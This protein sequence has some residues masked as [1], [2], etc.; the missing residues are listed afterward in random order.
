MK[1]INLFVFTFYTKFNVFYMSI[2]FGQVNVCIRTHIKWQGKIGKAKDPP[3][4][5]RLIQ[6]PWVP[7]YITKDDLVFYLSL[8]R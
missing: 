2:I 1:C 3:N 4:E 7:L 6:G 5:S 8:A